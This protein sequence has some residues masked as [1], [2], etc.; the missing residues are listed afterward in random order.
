[1]SK[2]L[3]NKTLF[4]IRFRSW[5]DRFRSGF[6]NYGCGTDFLTMLIRIVWTKLLNHIICNIFFKFWY[7]FLLEGTT[8]MHCMCCI[9]HYINVFRVLSKYV[10]TRIIPTY[11]TLRNAI[12]VGFCQSSVFLIK[13]K[14]T[15]FTYS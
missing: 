1:M 13:H 14:I 8:N 3:D 12:L 5:S 10:Y 4:S 6:F 7:I 9:I 15:L 2:N 11:N